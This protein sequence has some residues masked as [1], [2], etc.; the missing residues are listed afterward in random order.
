MK[1]LEEAIQLLKR[2]LD[3]CNSLE[4]GEGYNHRVQ[5]LLTKMQMIDLIYGVQLDLVGDSSDK[6]HIELNGKVVLE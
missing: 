1:T 3:V 4:Y 6:E 2:D 5:R